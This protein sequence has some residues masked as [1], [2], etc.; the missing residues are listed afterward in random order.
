MRLIER[1]RADVEARID[2]RLAE[3]KKQAAAIEGEAEAEIARLEK[4]ARVATLK[5]VELEKA[6][7][8]AKI[9]QS[10][11]QA[12]AEL[13]R[14]LVEQA[15]DGARKQLDELKDSEYGPL[16]E[17]LAA[18]ALNDLKA[19]VTISVRE[20]DKA[21][22]EAAASK[23]GADAEVEED[24]DGMGGGLMARSE[25]GS[26]YID[27]TLHTRLERC[28]IEGVTVAGGVLFGG[29]SAPKGNAKA[30]AEEAASE[31]ESEEE[32]PK[33]KAPAK[34]KSSKKRTARKK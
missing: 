30:A 7:R 2:A 24:L 27:N 21:R 19:K 15:F 5:R 20:G 31:D 8:S 11:K 33:K 16:F 29:A 6:R 13:K 17:A 25:D 26:V 18:E 12:E 4:T 28:R 34:K 14:D 22:A 10:V 23:A 9:L 3:A 32:A 1:M